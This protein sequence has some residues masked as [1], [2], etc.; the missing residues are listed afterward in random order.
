MYLV[1]FK[2]FNKSI[3][4]NPCLTTRNQLSLMKKIYKNVFHL[5]ILI[6]IDIIMPLKN[7][8]DLFLYFNNRFEVKLNKI[9]KTLKVK[10][11]E[12]MYLFH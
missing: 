7:N 5:I 8:L 6:K 12:E 9:K 11:I 4:F 10:Q 3:F 1:N 2:K